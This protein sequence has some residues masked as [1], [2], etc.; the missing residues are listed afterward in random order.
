MTAAVGLD[1]GTTGVK[2]I[3]VAPDGGVLARAERSY[4][5]STPR[6]GWSEQDPEDWWRAAEAAL[7]EVAA[8]REVVG[9]GLS[10]QM[11]GLVA[12]DADDRVIR[13]AILWN[14]QRTADECAE[15]EQAIGLERLIEL[16]GNRALPGFTAPKLLWL[17]RHE[18]A[19]YARI[20]RI[21]L[22]KDYVRLRLTRAWAMDVADASGTLLLDV[23]GRRWS[24]DVID[25]LGIPAAWLPPLLE[26][27]APAGVVVP[28]DDQLQGSFAAL[29]GV[30]VAA[31]A[32]DCAA[33]ALGVGIDRPGPLSIVLGTSGV[34][35]AALPAYRPEPE[36]RVHVFCHAVPGAWHAMGVMLSAAGSLQWFRDRLAPGASFDELLDEAARWDPGADRLVFLPYLAGERTP[37]ADPDARGAFVGLSLHHDRGAL[38]RAV[39]EGVAFGLRDSLDLLRSLGVEA[40]VA[41][42]SGGGARGG[43]WLRI[44]AAVL[45]VALETTASEEGSAYGAALLGGVAGGVFDDVHDAVTRCVRVSGRVEPEPGLVERYAALHG[46]FRSLYPALHQT[47][48]EP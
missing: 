18:P 19:A 4:P 31:G 3:A 14:D 32:G 1:V 12:L 11:H 33:A 43:E 6:P 16:T 45:G 42:V 34:V 27:P 5:L 2:A 29:R 24:R 13:P 7:A 39:L 23:A 17:R 20:A 36:A 46:R 41:R 40:D 37:H 47:E 25:A 8:G 22:P 15:I 9:I 38:V 21:C 30:P 10:G 44:V 26:S 48:E 28:C 35:F